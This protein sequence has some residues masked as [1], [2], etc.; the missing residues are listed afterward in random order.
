LA[1]DDL[2][3]GDPDSVELLSL[4]CR[5]LDGLAVAVVATARPWP[6]MALDQARLLV[7]DHLAALEHLAPL[8]AAA[9][10]ALLEQHLGP[11]LD[12]SFVQSAT[13]ACAGN[14]LLLG[15]VAQARRRGEDLLAGPAR[16]L[17]ERIFLPRFAG[18]GAP[19]LNWARAASVLGSRFRPD[20]VARLSGQLVQEAAEAMG[21]LLA[22]G[23]V[24][25][26]PDGNA[27][28]VHALFRQAVY[29]DLA[30]PLRQYLHAR[31]FTALLDEGA[32]PAEAAP[33]ARQA[34]LK[35]DARAVA[36]LGAAG[37]QALAAGAVATAAQHLEAAL[38]LAGATAGPGLHLELAGACLLA[39]KLVIADQVL[40]ELLSQEGLAGAERVNALRLHAQVL[41][42]S[43]RY[44]EA[45][46]CSKEASELALSRDPGLA[47]E[48]L[49]DDVFLSSWLE[50]PRQTWHRARRALG[51][52]EG[53]ASAEPARRLAA[54]AEG[55][56]GYLGGDP[57]HLD[58]LASAAQA[59]R[60]HLGSSWA[61]DVVFGYANVAKL[62][63]RFDDVQLMVGSLMAEAK[64]HGA[65]LSHR[66]LA[67]NHAD[68]LWRLGRLQDAR[69]LLD[70]TAELATLVP[71]LA[72]FAWVGLA[73]LCAEQ[74]AQA[75]SAM[76]AGRVRTAL[77]GT[78]ESLYLQL[79][80]CMLD[81]RNLLQAGRG[82]DAVQAAERAAEI[83]ERAGLVEP[84]IVPWHGAAIEAYVTVGR[85]EQAA[86]LAAN[87]QEICRPLPCHAPRAVAAWGQATIAWHCGDL[88][89]AEAGFQEALAHNAAVPMPLAEAETLVAYGRFLRHSGQPGRARQ[90]LHRA[91]V[92]L[93]PTGAGRLQEIIQHELAGAG[94]RRRRSPPPNELTAKEEQVAEL[95]AQGLTD[96]QIAQALFLSVKTVGHHLSRAYAKLGVSSRRELMLSGLARG[97][98]S[99]S[100]PPG[101]A[102]P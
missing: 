97:R 29:D 81:C 27:E 52:L 63:E 96:A 77:A 30:P 42:A 74:G 16:T 102:S 66:A 92:V 89:S 55:Y 70:E 21:A 59:E 76:W 60:Q 24:R 23:L 86:A 34:Q 53:S 88:E 91:L 38:S 67:I 15:E 2:H 35:G 41:L 12:P 17:A 83:A 33:H 84:C 47:A 14:P 72:P 7:H 13:R 18:V 11:G 98:S 1:V 99:P 58:D 87:L 93:E 100:S 3:W 73:Q 48:V 49:L 6:S 40:C 101:L 5:R 44:P 26:L 46:L 65:E 32:P 36:A 71:G 69:E 8:S 56:L 45:R 9:S 43:A 78:T 19:A 85:L 80:L 94:G 4:V 61:W 50:G 10:A 82:P 31:A 68:A 79:W 25:G 64:R 75:D 54:Y 22:A 57:G 20:L 51:L 37:R 95:A 62:S 90:L 39:G 28:F